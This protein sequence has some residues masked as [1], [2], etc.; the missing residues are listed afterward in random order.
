MELGAADATIEWAPK[1]RLPVYVAGYGPKALTLAGRVADG[2][3]FQVADPY[4]I[5]WGLQFVRAGAEEAGRSMDEIVIHCSTATWIS[6]DHAEAC[7]R[8]RW[9]PAVVGNHIADILRHHDP[10][11]LPSELFDY[12]HGR[13]A[14]DYRQHGHPGADHAQYVPDGICERFCVIG[15]EQECEA[16][17]LQ[18]AAIGV[19][20]FNIYPYVPD[21]EELIRTYGRTIAPRVRD[22]VAKASA[23]T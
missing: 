20:E 21:V 19:S 1:R 9:F 13:E 7:E 12:V 15:T 14:Y 3:I 4:F 16:K 23:S 11:G 18:L 5:E 22:A 8:V 10:G 6:D 2:I 17:I